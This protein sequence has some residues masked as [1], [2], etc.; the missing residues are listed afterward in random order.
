VLVEGYMWRHSAQTRRIA[1]LLP[2]LGELQ[3][4]HSSFFDPVLRPHDVRFVP[5]LGGG[6]LLDLGCYCVGVARLLA[7]REPDAVHGEAWLGRGAVDERFAGLL[8]FD[9]LVATFACGFSGKVNT[10]D[11]VGAS[12]VMHVPRAFSEPDGVVVVNGIEHRS[13]PGGDYRAQLDDFC[14]AIRGEG[15]PHAGAG[16]GSR[17]PAPVGR[18]AGRVGQFS[19]ARMLWLTCTG[20]PAASVW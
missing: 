4:I 10:L 14:A 20:T 8:R 17:C 2:A 5:S 3:S 9:D 7:G 13:A 1:E 19:R 15:T 6:A 11:V 12:G 16:V 18:N